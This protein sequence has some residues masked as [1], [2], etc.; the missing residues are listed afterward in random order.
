MAD[1]VRTTERYVTVEFRIPRAMFDQFAGYYTS[2]WWL[3]AAL[4]P[5]FA[6]FF[7]DRMKHREAEIDAE[8]AGVRDLAG[9]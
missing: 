4:R 1:I 7:R 8:L 6:E 2:K 3:M 5:A 9:S